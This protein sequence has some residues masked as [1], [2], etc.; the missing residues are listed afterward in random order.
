MGEVRNMREGTL[1]WVQASGSGVAWATAATPKSGL[2]GFVQAGG[3][4]AW[5][6]ELVPVEDRGEW[7]HWKRVRTQQPTFRFTVLEGVT[8]DWPESII[9]TASGASVKM[10]HLEFRERRS[11]LPSP[12]ALFYQLHGVAWPQGVTLTEQPEGNT[13]EYVAN[14][15]TGVMYTGSGYLS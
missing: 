13:R 4:I 11:E 10:V 7:S 8:A 2:F 5:G 9:G 14:A 12:S 15:L 6:D 1:R 3:A